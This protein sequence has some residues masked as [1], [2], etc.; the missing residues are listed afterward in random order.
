M[1]TI[2]IIG[3]GFSGTLT[4]VQLLRQHN[5]GEALR[6]VLIER[7]ATMARG[8]AYATRHAEHILNV[9]AGNMSALPD[10][11]DHF[12]R[13]CQRSDAATTPSSF[14]A[15]RQYGD[16]LAW[17]LEETEDK[18][19]ANI[20][21]LR[22]QGEATRIEYL[23]DKSGA[24]VSLAD[25]RSF[26]A[27]RVVLASGHDQPQNLQV[28]NADFYRSARYVRD[29]WAAGGIDSDT[30]TESTLLIGTG[31]TAVDICAMLTNNGYGAKVYAISRHGLLPQA[32]RVARVALPHD[33]LPQLSGD[34]LQS[35]R[36]QLRAIRHH[37]AVRTKAGDDWREVIA[38]LRP[39]TQWLW[40]NL[41]AAEKKR[42]LRHLR[43]Y[44]D[45][46]RH[47]VAP[48]PHALF[49]Q[50]IKSG[51]VTI[52]A[53]RIHDFRENEDGVQ[54][55]W[56]PR[57]RNENAILKVG[58]VINCTGPSSDLAR[59]GGGLIR[60]LVQHGMMRGDS[61]RL[62]LEVAENCALIDAQGTPS[63]VLFY[64]G[65]LLKARYWEAIAVPELRVFAQTLAK[66][67]LASFQAHAD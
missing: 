49:R 37:I 19:Q 12:L 11:P 39:H 31:L 27:D 48:Q 41:P 43:P 54:V 17:L 8:V 58:R 25:G 62:G 65:P 6:V 59:S 21:L 64:I 10:D 51:A 53:G 23:R 42:F 35:V 28:E 15:R 16:Y 63:E 60:Q 32:H 56:Q 38:A 40:H 1:Q 20:S 2:L 67:L 46:H 3:A 34:T 30:L 13:F 26:E 22:I 52:L 45:S 5:A 7:S 9:P 47:R 55:I 61:L 57:H 33:P 66:T 18:R 50:S 29:P 24:R 14:V 36:K 4:A 44:W